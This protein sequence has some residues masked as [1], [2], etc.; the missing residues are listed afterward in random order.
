MTN[1][2][3][4]T[5]NME[6]GLFIEKAIEASGHSVKDVAD[7]FGVK[8]QSVYQWRRR[9]IPGKPK[10]TVPK[11]ARL[12]ELLDFLGFPDVRIK[13]QGAGDDIVYVV[14]GP[15]LAR[16]REKIEGASEPVRRVISPLDPPDVK[17]SDADTV[18]TTDLPHDIPVLGISVGGEEA[19]FSMNGT[20]VDYVARPP[21]LMNARDIFALDVVGESMFPR[22]QPGDRIYITDTRPPVNGEDAVIEL[23]PANEGGQY[24]AFLK[25][26][27]GRTTTHIICEQFNPPGEVTFNLRQIRN[28]FRVIPTRELMG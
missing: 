10:P 24:P 11:A 13:S 17:A 18:K 22:F 20:I 12:Q 16:L 4:T 7:R 19:D 2:P 3:I 26:L 14:E 9:N 5:K 6:L 21:G 15:G 8:V 28:I 1:G 25:R 23:H 27:K